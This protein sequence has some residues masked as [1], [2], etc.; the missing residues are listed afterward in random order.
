MLPL[1]LTLRILSQTMTSELFMKM[2]FPF[3]KRMWIL[4]QGSD[5]CHTVRT[6]Q[7]KE[8]L[9]PASPAHFHHEPHL[10]C[11]APNHKRVYFLSIKNS[12]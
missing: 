11:D 10:L 5:S 2:K 8:C 7:Q 9:P 1:P 4:T 6:G 12:N 3:S